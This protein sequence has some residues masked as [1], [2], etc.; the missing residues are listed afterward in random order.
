M[1]RLLFRMFFIGV[2]T[3]I[4]TSAN[5][6]TSERAGDWSGEGRWYL[7]AGFESASV[8]QNLTSDKGV[9]ATYPSLKVGGVGPQAV[10]F[11]VTWSRLE[12]S[13]ANWRLSGLDGDLWLPYRPDLRLRPYLILGMGYHRY[14]G[15]ESEFLITNEA[16]NGARSLNAGLGIVG[17]ISRRTELTAAFRYR[18]LT[19]D[20]PDDDNGG[21]VNP[22]DATVSSISLGIQQLF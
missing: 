22:A 17:N 4:A 19:W 15:K 2:F 9:S 8:D 20:A 21:S 14:Y 18:Y 10:R 12:D 1:P 3:H 5:A 16:D 7:G 13:S 6:W 11:E